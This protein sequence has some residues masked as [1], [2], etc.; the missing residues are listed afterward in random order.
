MDDAEAALRGAGFEAIDS[1]PAFWMPLDEVEPAPTPVG[2]EVIRAETDDEV[3]E[4][5]LGDRWAGYMDDAEV[6]RTFPDPAS[7][8]G[9]GDRAFYLGR[10][11]GQLVATGQT[12]A[13]GGVV[14]TYG[15]WTADAH[16]RRGLAN[17]ILARG[18]LDARDRGQEIASIQAS[19]LGAGIYLRAGFRRFC[20]YRIFRPPM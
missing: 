3:I 1:V 13:T 6:A 5:L 14:G 9:E 15:L 16:R 17:A 7:M 18:L 8:A 10:Y 19:E 4:C 11:Q 2:Y 20:D 12:V